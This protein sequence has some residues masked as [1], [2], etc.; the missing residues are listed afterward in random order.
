M[1]INTKNGDGG[2]TSLVHGPSI[3]KSDDRIE[4]LGT[5]DELSA[6]WT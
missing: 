2:M 5:L 6:I 1:N 4:L 3:P